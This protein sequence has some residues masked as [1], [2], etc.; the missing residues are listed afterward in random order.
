MRSVILACAMAAALVACGQQA[1][2]KIEA[3]AIPE[4]PGFTLTLEQPAQL[5][6]PE[7]SPIRISEGD[8]GLRLQGNVAN[9]NGR[10]DV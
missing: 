7:G 4:G 1:E 5:T 9:P 6:V 8:I 3:P 10:A 2:E